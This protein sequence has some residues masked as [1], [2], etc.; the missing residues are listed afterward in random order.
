MKQRRSR[1]PTGRESL[2]RK[3][4]TPPE[5]TKMA[6]HSWKKL[7]RDWAIPGP[8]VHRIGEKA[9]TLQEA[10]LKMIPEQV[11]AATEE[12]EE[13]MSELFKWPHVKLEKRETKT[14]RNV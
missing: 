1:L 3:F 8:D 7:Q 2:D 10:M 9:T 14:P 4:L 11:R 12:L 5:S 13:S 6:L